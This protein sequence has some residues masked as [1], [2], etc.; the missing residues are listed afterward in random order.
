LQKTK[1]DSLGI[2]RNS[3][4]VVVSLV[5]PPK[6]EEPQ[7]IPV[8]TRDLANLA[9]LRYDEWV[10]EESINNIINNNNNEDDDEDW[11]F[12]PQQQQQQQQ[13]QSPP[14]PSRHAFRMA[15]AEM[16][17]ERSEEGAFSFLAKWQ[18]QH[19]DTAAAAAAEEDGKVAPVL[20]A[21]ELS[22]GEFEGALRADDKRRFRWYV[23]DVVASVEHRRMGVAS[24]LMDALETH[25][26][27]T[28]TS[29]NNDVSSSPPIEGDCSETAVVTLYLHVRPDNDAAMAFYTSPQR[30][31]APPTD[32]ELEGL[33]ADRLASN[34]G[35]TG[36]VLLCKTLTQRN[37]P[38]LEEPTVLSTKPTPGEEEQQRKRA[39]GFGSTSAT[40]T[41]TKN[42]SKKKNRRKKK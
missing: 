42:Q 40:T 2:D 33:D 35:T 23:T 19:H 27:K 15:T 29:H 13:P 3:G 30:G 41:T 31:Y 22:P 11:S 32:R 34:A 17:G 39:R 21:A 8:L 1:K 24:A 36:Q 14:P 4:T 18:P 26:H 12:L 37:L 9:D 20:G 5:E 16:V 28:T 7:Q 25:A 38:V 10:A 6:F